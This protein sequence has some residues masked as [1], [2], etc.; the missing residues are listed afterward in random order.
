[1]KLIL[2]IFSVFV[3]VNGQ[4]GPPAGGPKTPSSEGHKYDLGEIFEFQ[5]LS[6]D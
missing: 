1:M 5:F 6:K 4:A 3:V 2:L